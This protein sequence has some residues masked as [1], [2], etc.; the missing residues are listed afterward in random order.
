M[1]WHIRK[2]ERPEKR[3]TETEKERTKR[4]TREEEEKKKERQKQRHHKE[5]ER[6]KIQ[7][8]RGTQGQSPAWQPSSPVLAFCG[9]CCPLE[10]VTGNAGLHTAH[11]SPPRAL[12]VHPGCVGA[13]PGSRTTRTASVF[14]SSPLLVLL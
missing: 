11:L 7:T 13:S 6:W 4:D 8:G 10:V 12:L 9:L 3:K 5:R 14:L 1:S 2:T